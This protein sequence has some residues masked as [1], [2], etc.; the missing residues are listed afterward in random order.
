MIL[1]EGDK[2]MCNACKRK[3][4]C[5][6][7]IEGFNDWYGRT[8]VTVYFEGAEWDHCDREVFYLEDLIPVQTPTKKTLVTA[9]T[10]Q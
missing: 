7:T 5:V 4:N 8:V 1:R 6:G 2:V 3:V 9:G 10:L